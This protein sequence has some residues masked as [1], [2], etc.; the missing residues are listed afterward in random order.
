MSDTDEEQRKPKPQSSSTTYMSEGSQLCRKG[1]YKMATESY[2][3]ALDQKPDDKLCLVLRSKCFLMRGDYNNALTDAEASLKEDKMYHK[4]LYQKAEALY[5]LGDFEF[6]LVFYHR[7][8]KL[9]PDLQHFRLGIQK[10]EKAIDNTLG[11]RSAVKLEK[12]PMKQQNHKSGKSE[13]ITKQLL[14]PFY[15]DK[16]YLECLLKD[17]GKKNPKCGETMQDLIQDCVTYIDTWTDF[18]HKEKPI[19]ARE[20]ARK[21]THQKKSQS[22]QTMSPDLAQFLFKSLEE[23]DAALMSGNAGS[24]LK[25]AQTLMKTVKSWSKEALPKKK[26]VLGS[27]HCCMAKAWITLGDMDKALVHYQKDLNLA[28]ECK[29]PDAKSRALHNIGALYVQTGN[30]TQA[31]E[32]W[33]ESIPLVR[34][35]TERTWLFHEIGRCYLDLQ[36]DKEA[37]DYGRRSLAAA[38]EIEDE[39]WVLN[40]NVLVAQAESNLGNFESCVSHFERALEQAKMVQDAYAVDAI[41]K[42]IYKAGQHLTQ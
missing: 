12:H 23:I 42:A 18:W 27:L 39:K 7:G 21:L 2:S 36:R 11:S 6:A 26:E 5:M 22:C 28:K 38:E 4:G 13:K 10:A 40:A 37:R 8:N 25:K 19:Y 20:S 29:L 3:K 24:G 32:V 30:F 41:E 15:T 9:R 31:V 35:D 14:G 17:E 1:K 34:D 16:K 33:E